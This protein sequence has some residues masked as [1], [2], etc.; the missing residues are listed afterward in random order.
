[1]GR[2]NP[3]PTKNRNCQCLN[4]Q[5]WPRPWVWKMPRNPGIYKLV[6]CLINYMT[7]IS[8][9]FPNDFS[10]SSFSKG[11]FRQ[12]CPVWFV[13]RRMLVMRSPIVQKF[14]N[15]PLAPRRLLPP[16]PDPLPHWGRGEKLEP[17]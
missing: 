17:L 11:G 6:S 8:T 12:H 4:E 3:A 14:A 1:M 10:K 7:N 15:G 2:G 5:H 16:H 13:H 9:H